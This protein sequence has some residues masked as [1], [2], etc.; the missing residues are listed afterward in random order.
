MRL[1]IWNN[2]VTA[3]VLEGLKNVFGESVSSATRDEVLA[4][5]KSG[6]ADVALIPT[7]VAF[8]SSD[9]FDLLPAVAISSWNN[10]FAWLKVETGLSTKSL[11]IIHTEDGK[12]SA[13]LSAIVLKEHY[14]IGATLSQQDEMPAEMQNYEILSVEDG[15]DAEAHTD[16]VLL[17]LGQDGFEMAK[18]EA[19]NATIEAIRDAVISIDLNRVELVSRWKD[20]VVMESYF[21]NDLRLRLDDLAVASLVELSEHLY[22]VGATTDLQPVVF[23]SLPDESAE[24]KPS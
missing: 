23:V 7:D 22:Y 24:E 13:L 1:T 18:G 14:A 15:G 19:D 20:D 8:S 16:P 2:P 21:L 12:L 3:P 6:L 11:K 17:D 4:D 9:D 5:L 10:P